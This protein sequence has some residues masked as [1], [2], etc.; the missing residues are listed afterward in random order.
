MSLGTFQSAF[1]IYR[2]EIY[3]DRELFIADVFQIIANFV[4]YPLT[5]VLIW[6]LRKRFTNSTS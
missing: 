2:R 3:F 4:I 5:A 1:E 6:K